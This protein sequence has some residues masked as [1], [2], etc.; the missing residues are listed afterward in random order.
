MKTLLRRP[1]TFGTFSWTY[2]RSR[3]CL[4][5]F[6]CRDG[7]ND[8]S[9]NSSETAYLLEQVVDVEIHLQDSLLTA[10]VMQRDDEGPRRWR[11]DVEVNVWPPGKMIRKC[12]TTLSER[13]VPVVRD[14][15]L[16]NDPLLLQLS[17]GEPIRTKH[18][19]FRGLLLFTTN[20]DDANTGR[21]ALVLG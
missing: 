18:L 15:A 4:L 7:Q 2:S 20:S 21:G 13:D 1:S 14:I 10:L 12:S 5:S 8:A 9:P 3:R 16:H 6:C 11:G 17:V 19:R